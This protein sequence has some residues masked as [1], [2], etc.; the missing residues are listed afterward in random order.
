V[1]GEYTVWSLSRCFRILIQSRV[2]AVDLAERIPLTPSPSPTLGQGEPM[3][4][5][6]LF[7]TGSWECHYNLQS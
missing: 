4:A 7:Q 3:L 6:V 5:T 1:R 2:S